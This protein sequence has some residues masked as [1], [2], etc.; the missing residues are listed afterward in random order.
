MTVIPM[1]EPRTGHSCRV[2][3]WQGREIT[4][5]QADSFFDWA[6]GEFKDSPERCVID[7]GRVEYVNA[8][9]LSSML[10]VNR[11]ASYK[12]V[13]LFWRSLDKNVANLVRLAGLNNVFITVD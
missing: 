1:I 10:R 2:C 12:G 9:G 4:G 5:T 3:R 7:L 11:L 13:H 8:A 6:A